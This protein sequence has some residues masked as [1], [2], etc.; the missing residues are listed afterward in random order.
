DAMSSSRMS[1]YDR[2]LDIFDGNAEP[3]RDAARER[4][5]TAKAAGHELHYW[6]QDEGGK[7]AEKAYTPPAAQL[8]QNFKRSAG[9]WG[10]RT[11]P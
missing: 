9:N 5:K 7:W 4:W 11:S 8:V 10:R 3:M 6:Q 2:C 1:E